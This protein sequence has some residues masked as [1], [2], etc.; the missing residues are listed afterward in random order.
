MNIKEPHIK[1]YRRRG[2]WAVFGEIGGT[3]R[4]GENYRSF[5]GFLSAIR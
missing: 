1:V 4:G 5:I 2:G 3:G